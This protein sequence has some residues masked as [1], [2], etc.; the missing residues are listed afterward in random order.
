MQIDNL[1]NRNNIIFLIHKKK[2]VNSWTAMEDK[3]LLII[4][5]N[6]GYQ[7]WKEIS[8]NF[9]GK[10]YVQCY[11]RFKRIRPNGINGF[12]TEEEDQ[13]LLSL[14]DTYGRD[15]KMISIHML[16]RSSKQIRDRF[17]NSLDP[18]L[19][20]TKFT[21]KEDDIIIKAYKRLGSKWTRIA[22]LLNCRNGDL[23]KNRFYSYLKKK[24]HKI[25]FE[26]TN[27]TCANNN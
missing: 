13:R 9:P 27:S 10:S 8:K 12:W 14:Y 4:S 19:N 1:Q 15:W 6:F 25:N 22:E 11:S 24:V 20:K 26:S 21:S 7:N 2:R 18:K 16:S 17:I 3:L 5:R 23:V